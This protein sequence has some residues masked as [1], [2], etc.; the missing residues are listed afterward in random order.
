MVRYAR[1]FLYSIQLSS[2]DSYKTKSCSILKLKLNHVTHRHQVTVTNNI[3]SK[4]QRPVAVWHIMAWHM[5]LNC[6]VKLT[7]SGRGSPQIEGRP[8]IDGRRSFDVRA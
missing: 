2:C 4:L 6:A 7:L 1:Y 3:N 5:T 8:S